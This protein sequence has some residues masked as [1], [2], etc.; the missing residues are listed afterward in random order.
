MFYELSNLNRK[1]QHVHANS[2]VVHKMMVRWQNI[3]NAQRQITI[4]KT[5]HRKPTTEQQ[6]PEQNSRSLSLCTIEEKNQ[7][8]LDSVFSNRSVRINCLDMMRI[9]EV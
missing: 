2:Y 1:T 3:K 9:F 4:C 8:K 5:N 7:I 6:K